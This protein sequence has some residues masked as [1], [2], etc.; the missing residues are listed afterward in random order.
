MSSKTIII[1]ESIY[2]VDEVNKWMET[3]SS[4]K[5]SRN[6]RVVK[7]TERIQAANVQ[8]HNLMHAF[9][10]VINLRGAPVSNRQRFIFET[11]LRA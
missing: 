4:L 5:R 2:I 11:R 8:S 1:C 7:Q 10:F 9:Y 6:S 3:A